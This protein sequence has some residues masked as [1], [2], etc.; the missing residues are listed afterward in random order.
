MLAPDVRVPLRPLFSTVFSMDR[1]IGAIG[2]DCLD[3]SIRE[4]SREIVSETLDCGAEFLSYNGTHGG[5]VL[6]HF[7]NVLLDQRSC[8][9][10]SWFDVDRKRQKC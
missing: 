3:H 9:C 7:L 4:T 10:V 2:A 1:A 5:T 8:V 6:L